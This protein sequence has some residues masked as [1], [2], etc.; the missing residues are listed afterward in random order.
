MSESYL[1]SNCSST[2]VDNIKECCCSRSS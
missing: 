1:N 2:A